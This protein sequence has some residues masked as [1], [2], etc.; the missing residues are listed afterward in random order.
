VIVTLLYR[1]TGKGLAVDYEKT[2]GPKPER[3]TFAFE[4]R[5]E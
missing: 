5:R 3:V 4:R 1:S 2:G